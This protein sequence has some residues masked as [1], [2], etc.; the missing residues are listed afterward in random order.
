MRALIMQAPLNSLSINHCTTNTVPTVSSKGG[1]ST[2]VEDGY[3]LS[4]NLGSRAV[5]TNDR[6]TS[7][8]PSGEGSS[9]RVRDKGKTL[10]DK[11]GAV[12]VSDDSEIGL[13]DLLN[14]MGIFYSFGYHSG[15]SKLDHANVVK[16][17]QHAG[18]LSGINVEC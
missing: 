9:T 7:T 4:G 18:E 11:P 6:T 10:L 13:V 1:P 3:K 17:L 15:L 14:Q 8:V 5:S 2:R 12:D 16:L